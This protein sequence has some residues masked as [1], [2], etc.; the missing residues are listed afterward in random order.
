MSGPLETEHVACM[1][2][3][4]MADF[5]VKTHVVFAHL[6]VGTARG[7]RAKNHDTP[8]RNGN[9][10]CRLLASMPRL[11]PLASDPNLLLRGP[12]HEPESRGGARGQSPKKCDCPL[13]N[14]YF[15]WC[16]LLSKAR[17]WPL[18]SALNPLL[19][20]PEATRGQ[21]ARGPPGHWCIDKCAI[22]MQ[23]GHF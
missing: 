20:S 18:A 14:R 17:L 9:F 16:R 10:R 21:G 2:W 13:R 6:G 4:M 5:T 7:R 1:C 22:L 23:N 8:I 11:W 15:C 12:S 19:R 3:T